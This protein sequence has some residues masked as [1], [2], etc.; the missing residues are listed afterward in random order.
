MRSTLAFRPRYPAEL[1]T[2]RTGGAVAKAM[3]ESDAWHNFLFYASMIE[4]ATCHAHTIEPDLLPFVSSAILD[5]S[6]IL[7]SLTGLNWVEDGLPSDGL[8]CLV[9]GRLRSLRIKIRDYIVGEDDDCYE[10]W[11]S[12]LSLKI[13]QLCPNIRTFRVHAYWHKSY[14][15][16]STPF[17]ELLHTADVVFTGAEGAYPYPAHVEI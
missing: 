17:F 1:T 4:N 14:D 12:R 2:T 7:C 5:H 11:I 15:L 3:R 13:G 10:E 16:H 9:G 6:P 8:L